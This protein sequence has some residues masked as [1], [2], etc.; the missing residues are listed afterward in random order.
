MMWIRL[1][2]VSFVVVNDLLERL[3][4]AVKGV[5]GE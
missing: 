5:Y 3:D 1:R 4:V 2:G